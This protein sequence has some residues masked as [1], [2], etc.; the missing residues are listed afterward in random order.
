MVAKML[1]ERE[2]KMKKMMNRQGA[3]GKA[4]ATATQEA[5]EKGLRERERETKIAAAKA[6]LAAALAEIEEL[7][8]LSADDVKDKDDDDK[9]FMLDNMPQMKTDDDYELR[10]E[11]ARMATLEASSKLVKEMME[12]KE[13]AEAWKDVRS[14]KLS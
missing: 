4:A 5:I 11:E 12:A 3:K 1:A 13:K 10:K 2:E 8:S 14:G 9:Q 7:E 6:K